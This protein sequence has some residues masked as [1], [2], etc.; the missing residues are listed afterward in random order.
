MDN[1]PNFFIGGDMMKKSIA[2]SLILCSCLIFVFP[3]DAGASVSLE[4]RGQCN[5]CKEYYNVPRARGYQVVLRILK[6]N[7]N[8]E[9]DFVRESFNNGVTLQDILKEKDIDTKEFEDAFLSIRLS[10]V[11][12]AL[13]NGY[14]SE[15]TASAI[16]EK[17]NSGSMG[18]KVE[19]FK[20]RCG[21]GC[22]GGGR[23]K[24]LR[25]NNQN[26]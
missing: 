22:R 15:D 9:E 5:S 16:K 14:I 8:L 11:D 4:P 7:Y 25:P 13:E 24:K 17:L 10:E 2:L 6:N 21:R 3:F 23:M 12:S 18:F 1:F 26:Q 20:K 19:N